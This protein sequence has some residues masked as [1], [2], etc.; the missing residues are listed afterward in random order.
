MRHWASADVAVREG[1][2]IRRGGGRTPPAPC[3]GSTL[4]FMSLIVKN[5]ENATRRPKFQPTALGGA[6]GCRLSA[7]HVRSAPCPSS[8]A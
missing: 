3:S 4:M 5:T 2:E 7:R 8:S 1:M 6:S